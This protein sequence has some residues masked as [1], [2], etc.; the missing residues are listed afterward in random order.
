MPSGPVNCLPFSAVVGMEDCK[1]ALECALVNPNIRTVLLRGGS[2]SAKTTLARAA[3]G[4]TNR[5]IINCP[6]NITDEQLFGGIDVEEAIKSGKTAM[7]KGLLSEADGNIL[8][9]D[10]VNLMDRGMLAGILD[11]VSTGI[12]HVERGPI[13]SSYT[14]DTTLVATMNPSDTDLSS[15]VL[16]RFDLCAYT[17]EMGEKE[18]RSVLSRNISF[19]EDPKRFS[20]LYAEDEE[21]IRTKI[22][23]GMRILPLVTVS[24]ELISV[25]SEL[26]I[27]V[28]AD[29][30]R[31]IG[32]AHV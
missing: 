4:I 23:R 31:E 19:A 15:H 1:R 7:K 10:D 11:A 6:L 22:V 13:S 27:K 9:I 17:P 16:D 24:D 32:R 5:K 3:A 21:E 8:Y 25:I 14:C 29:G 18:K 30:M 2:G 12:V 20:E 26:C 28:A